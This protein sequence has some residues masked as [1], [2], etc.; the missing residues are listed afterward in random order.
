MPVEFLSDDQVAVF[1]QFAGPVS[2]AELE[3]FFFLDE[4]DLELAG[5]R[6]AAGSRLGFGVQLGRLRF[7]GTFLDDRV[8]VPGSVVDFVATQ[9]GVVDCSVL[10]SYV[11]RSKT[12]YE[13]RWEIAQAYGYRRL[14]VPGTAAEFRSFLTARA[15]TRTERPTQLFDRGVA[16]LRAERVLLP[17]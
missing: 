5:R 14:S 13:H 2:T 11:E 16:G 15:W 6:R 10:G 1:G 7:L 3:R 17:V 9:L 12:P 4:R 8:A